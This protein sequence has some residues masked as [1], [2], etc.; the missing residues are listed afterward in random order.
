[1]LTQVVVFVFHTSGRVL[2]SPVSE[3][4]FSVD[5]K[6]AVTAANDSTVCVHDLAR[7]K[8]SLHWQFVGMS[9]GCFF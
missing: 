2:T 1:V 8:A 4:H 9:L 3:I 6:Y 7:G 5:G